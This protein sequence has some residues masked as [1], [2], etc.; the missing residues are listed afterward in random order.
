[1]I[2]YRA[3]AYRVHYLGQPVTVTPTP[4]PA[5]AP[6]P[7]KPNVPII[8]GVGAV[9]G[10]ILGFLGTILAQKLDKR[11]VQGA[12]MRKFGALGGVLGGLLGGVTA[13]AFKD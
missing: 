13:L 1:M 4:A 11:M 9:G 2:A 12:S 8:L 6:A 5:V 10:A 3:P 7:K